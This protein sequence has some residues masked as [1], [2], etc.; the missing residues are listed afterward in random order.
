MTEK[1]PTGS[2]VV[3]TFDGV[4]TYDDGAGTVGVRDAADTYGYG[5]HY[6]REKI[7]SI[8]APVQR[9]GAKVWHA[10][11]ECEFT[12]VLHEPDA[13]A[14]GQY[15]LRDAQGNLCVRAD[16]DD[17]I[18]WAEWKALNAPEELTWVHPPPEVMSD[19]PQPACKTCRDTLILPPKDKIVIK[20]GDEHC[21][22]CGASLEVPF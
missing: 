11:E 17:I 8:R 1:I 3:V 2:R 6:S 5:K 20:D 13:G 22:D 4:V 19:E 18:P 14:C 9:A 10:D 7:D 15:V 16:A 12:V 21:A